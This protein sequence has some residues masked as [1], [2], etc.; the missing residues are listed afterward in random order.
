ML[1]W[2]PK[3][4]NG[5]IEDYDEAID[6]KS[7]YAPAYNFRGYAYRE[8]GEFELALQD[9][10]EAIRLRPDYV[11]AYINRGM[12]FGRKGEYGRALQDLDKAISNSN[13]TLQMPIIIAVLVYNIKG[14]DYDR[15][16]EDYTTGR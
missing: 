12:A 11:D 9:L 16:I 1:D 13:Q 6:R 7:D 15:A 8:K 2:S 3:S 10:N 14:D 5:A 4:T